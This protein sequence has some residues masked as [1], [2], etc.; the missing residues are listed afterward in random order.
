MLYSRIVLGVIVL[1][2]G[3]NF[4]VTDRSWKLASAPR[5][6]ELGTLAE[7]PAL[8][9]L[10]LA[11][12]VEGQPL[13]YPPGATPPAIEGRQPLKAGIA[14]RE[15]SL[16]ALPLWAYPEPGLATYV[17]RSGDMQAL[18]L[19]AEQAAELDAATGY[20]Y[21]EVRFAWWTHLWG[22][23][24]LILILI[25]TKARSID[26]RKAEEAELVRDMAQA[27]ARSA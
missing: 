26:I 16:F 14:Y 22:W 8:A 7:T 15:V 12:E 20:A 19:H 18:P 21:S 17:E 27:E 5:M 24:L 4:A 9:D 23:S 6:M 11:T 10:R 3:I 1:F 13:A 25:W 2:V